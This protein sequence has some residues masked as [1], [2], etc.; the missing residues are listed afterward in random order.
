MTSIVSTNQYEYHK[1]LTEV[2]T[3]LETDSKHITKMMLISVTDNSDVIIDYN[4][5]STTDFA[6]IAGTLLKESIKS[7]VLE[8]LELEDD[9]GEYDTETEV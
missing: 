5:C 4:N 3:N 1:W 7:E 2:L 9:Y 8:D 6:L